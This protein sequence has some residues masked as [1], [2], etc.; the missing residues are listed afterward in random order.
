MVNSDL[1]YFDALAN[2]W[3]YLIN[4]NNI[5]IYYNC[6]SD[7]LYI[8]GYC[9]ADWGNNLNNRR[10]TTDYLFSLLNISG[11]TNP[12]LWNS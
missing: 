10:L 7:N 8:K 3:Y 12:I 4:Y 5:D 6:N 11:I 2:I 1:H 9:D